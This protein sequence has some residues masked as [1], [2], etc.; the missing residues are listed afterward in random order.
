MVPVA[1]ERDAF[2]EGY[3]LSLVDGEIRWRRSKGPPKVGQ[4]RPPTSAALEHA[5]KVARLVRAKLP[6]LDPGDAESAAVQGLLQAEDRYAPGGPASFQ[7]YSERRIRGAILDDFDATAYRK[8]GRDHERV[9]AHTAEVECAAG[10]PDG[11]VVDMVAA[12]RRLDERERYVLLMLGAGYRLHELAPELGVS[13]MRVSQISTGA[14][15]KLRGW[16]SPAKGV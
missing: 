12:L 11:S 10:P 16:E 6:S 7:T 4:W 14:K 8:L 15:R 5:R 3:D 1:W 13:V 9:S 2:N